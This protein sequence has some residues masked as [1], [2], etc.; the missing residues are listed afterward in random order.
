MKTHVVII[1]DSSGSM[2]KIKADTIGGF[3]SF[4]ADQEDE[5]GTATVS[6]YDFNTDVDCEFQG[7]LLEEAPRLDRDRYTP[8]GRTALYDAIAIASVNEGDRLRGVATDARPDQV[9][10][11]ILTDGKE[12]ASETSQKRVRE[13]VE[14]RQA[15]SGWEYLFIGANQDAILAASEVGIEEERAL[16]MDHSEEGA[17]AAY[18]S[19][20]ENISQARETGDTGGFNEYQR[21]RQKDAGDDS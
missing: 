1:L 20:S 6:L 12:N 5:P 16:N 8:S 15:E 17:E 14:Q 2:E 13:I 3:N 9:V 19:V 21:Q 4:L 10:V 11:V 18:N 7:R